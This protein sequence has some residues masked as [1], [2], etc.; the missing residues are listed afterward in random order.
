VLRASEEL[1]VRAVIVDALDDRAASFYRHFGFDPSDVAPNTLMV[2]L[3]AIRRT[4][5][6]DR[7]RFYHQS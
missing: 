7:S 2:S 1:A 4:L 3:Q 6:P 5:E